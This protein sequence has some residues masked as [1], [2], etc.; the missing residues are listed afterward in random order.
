MNILGSVSTDGSVA[1]FW[2]ALA[3]AENDNGIFWRPER[4][5]SD[6]IG[7]SKTSDVLTNTKLLQKFLTNVA[8]DS[9]SRERVG[10]GGE[11]RLYLIPGYLYYF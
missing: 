2:Q 1:S 11:V 5:E 9:I 10:R 7:R 4:A 3:C 8:K 6:A